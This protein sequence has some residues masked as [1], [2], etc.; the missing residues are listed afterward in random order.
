[1]V[2]IRAAFLASL[3]LSDMG[4]PAALVAPRAAGAAAEAPVLSTLTAQAD[5]ILAVLGVDGAVSARIKTPES[6]HAKAARKGLRPDQVLDRI[7]LRVLVDD[8]S[9]C[10]AV[11]SA[12]LARYP[13]ISESMD[14]YIAE[15]KPNGYRSLHM[16]VRTPVGVA[17]YQ[18][19]TH[20][21]HAHAEHGGAAHARYKAGAFV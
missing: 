11:R 5:D 12:L 4:L 13:V 6:L 2:L 7:G 19:R 8:E 14:D 20:E 18:I 21:M 17:E 9:D 15:P 1:M 10:Y 16:A 3:L